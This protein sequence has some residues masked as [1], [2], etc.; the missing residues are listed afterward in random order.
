MEWGPFFTEFR[1]AGLTEG[2]KYFPS[3]YQSKRSQT[4]PQNRKVHTMCPYN[5]YM[6][7]TVQ[8][9]VQPS[10]WREETDIY[11]HCPLHIWLSISLMFTDAC[12]IIS[13]VYLLYL[14]II[15]NRKIKIGQRIKGHLAVMG[16][17]YAYFWPFSHTFRQVCLV[18]SPNMQVGGEMAFHPMR[19][20]SVCSEHELFTFMEPKP[21]NVIDQYNST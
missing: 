10:I 8:V 4:K 5:N 12:S 7:Q 9:H 3:A 2:D 16:W 1:G 17:R 15:F 14:W 13:Y 19:A 18:F 21:S 11:H 6:L 20:T